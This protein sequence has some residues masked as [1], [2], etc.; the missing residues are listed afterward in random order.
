[1]RAKGSQSGRHLQTHSNTI[2]VSLQVGPGGG[3]RETEGQKVVSSCADSL[4]LFQSKLAS[5]SNDFKSVLEV[6]TEVSGVCGGGMGAGMRLHEGN[7]RRQ[8]E[9]GQGHGPQGGGLT[10]LLP[11]SLR[12]F[13]FLPQTQNLKQQR[14]RREQFSR[15]PVSALP[16]A[17]NHLGESQATGGP[18]GY[19][20]VTVFSGE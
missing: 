6:R 7:G 5:M 19:S 2:V 13:A 9:G 18:E 1:M 12:T 14:S 3:R 16:L 4:S 11:G 15:A 20:L 8:A 17:P 10:H